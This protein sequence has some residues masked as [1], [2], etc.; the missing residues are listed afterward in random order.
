MRRLAILVAALAV[1]LFA[2]TSVAGAAATTLTHPSKHRCKQVR[3][4]HHG[5]KK[6]VCRHKRHHAASP[7]P[8]PAPEASA[9]APTVTPSPPVIVEEPPAEEEPPIEEVEDADSDGVPDSSDNCVSVANPSQVDSDADGFGDACDPCPA[10]PDPS[11]YCPATIYQINRGEIPGGEKVALINALVI[12]SSP[13]T[14]WV[15]AKESDSG[16]E[17]RAY[18]G[19]DVDVSSLGA[20]P[21]QGDRISVNGTSSFNSAGGSLGA[22][23]IQ[24]ESA[25]GEVFTPYAASATEFTEVSKESELNDLLVSVP[26]LKR[27]SATGT[28][29]WA[30]SGGIF[31]GNSIIGE[32]PSGSYTDGQTFNSITGIAEVMEELHQLLPRGGS[33]IVP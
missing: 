22:E 7:A 16:Y 23:A 4:N 15:A 9:P 18:S 2:V 13:N 14:I 12:A 28:T 26:G 17:G 31:L 33:D 1:A 6:R 30:M 8:L 32:L 21:A 3:K 27:E 20:A 5:K 24:V 10:T 11:G 25:L 29:S 19:L